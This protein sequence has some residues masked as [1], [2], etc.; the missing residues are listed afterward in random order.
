MKTIHSAILSMALLV[1]CGSAGARAQDLE[2]A[3]A[4]FLKSCGTCH[5]ADPNSPPRQGPNLATVYGRKAGTFPGFNYSAALKDGGW[6]WDD[7][8]L[9]AWMENP[10]ALHPGTVMNYRQRDPDKRALTLEYL[11]TLKANP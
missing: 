8:A 4:Q 6:V 2:A 1:A 5:S 7:A 3:K 9:L 11:K 10:Q